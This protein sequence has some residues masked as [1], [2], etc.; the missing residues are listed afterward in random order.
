M[1]LSVCFGVID[2]E[3]QISIGPREV[4]VAEWIIRIVKGIIVLFNY[5]VL[6]R[7]I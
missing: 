5:L 2:V 4:E 1:F 6:K 3:D 7:M